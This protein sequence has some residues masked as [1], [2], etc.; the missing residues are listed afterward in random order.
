[1]AKPL[2][3][4]YLMGGFLLYAL[5]RDLLYSPSKQVAHDYQEK[6]VQS[7]G[8]TLRI[9][10]LNE[11]KENA[12]L[13]FGGNNE[14]V[15]ST[16]KRRADNL[17]DFTVYL[18]NYRGYGGSTGEPTEVGLYQDALVIYDTLKPEHKELY[19]LGRSLGSGVASYVASKREVKKVALVTPYDS[20]RSVAQSKYPMYP[21]DL[22]LKDK[23]DSVENLSTAK[24]LKVLILMVEDDEIIPNEHS[25]ALANSMLKKQV[26]VE[27]IHNQIHNSIS[28]SKEYFDFLNHFFD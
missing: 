14:S 12:I 22:I 5:Q 17:S 19:L 28:K 15:L 20:V 27:V 3:M 18:V 25:Y 26:Q 11:G 9:I 10:V 2:L 24:H 7:E 1:M 21:I 23:F 16:A 4:L 6:I 8:E 13:Y